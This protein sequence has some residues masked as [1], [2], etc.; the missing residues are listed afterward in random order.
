[1]AAQ[2]KPVKKSYRTRVRIMEA[3]IDLM[4][5]KDFDAIT[6]KSLVEKANI[7]R[8]TFYLYFSDIYELVAY[9]EDILLEDMPE[10]APGDRPRRDPRTLPTLAEC[11]ENAWERAWFE[12]YD[13]CS[14]YFNALLGP[15][16]DQ[17]F[18]GKVKKRLQEALTTSM[19]LDGMPTDKYQ[20]YFINL[21]PQVFLFLAKEWTCDRDSGELQLENIVT[22]ASMIRTGSIYQRYLEL[23]NNGELGAGS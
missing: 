23:T 16:G 18:A 17:S 19:G 20:D 15:H 8:G 21:L 7:T 13:K 5:D 10:L 6:V 12:Y 22:M 3:F 1:M 14:R 9:I 11:T 4:A 2:E